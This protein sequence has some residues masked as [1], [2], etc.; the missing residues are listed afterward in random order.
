[1]SV[2]VTSK[3]PGTNQS[4]AP[5]Q[6]YWRGLHVPFIAPWSGESMPLGT[7]VRRPGPEGDGIAYADEY[8]QADRRNGVLWLRAGVARGRG[9][10]FFAEV[11]ALR[12]RQ[13]MTHLLCQV[14]GS[15][16]F[17]R[18]D[19]RHLFLLRG[20]EGE[21]IAEGEKTTAPPICEPCAYESL[22]ACPHLRRGA[23]AALVGY[24]PYWG[25]AGIVYDPITLTPML[26]DK[27]DGLTLIGFDDPLIRWTLAARSVITLNE[28][29][30]VDLK[31]ELTTAQRKLL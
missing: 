10:P 9:K 16:T 22:R 6:N 1:M 4:G 26:S 21:P 30:T 3:A 20:E 25:V 15:S 31:Q 14:C 27:P 7:I 2:A 11:H 19:E 29:T 17:G 5:R 13:A 28:C 23:A 12:Q 24:T 18:D 8:S